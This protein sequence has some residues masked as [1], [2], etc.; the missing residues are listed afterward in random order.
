MKAPEG[1][2]GEVM[3][4]NRYLALCGVASR[5]GAMELVF[6]ERVSVNA[7]LAHDPGMEIHC[8]EDRVTLDGEWVRP[9]QHWVVYAF[10]KPRGVV[11]SM[12]DELGR[13]GLRPYLRRIREAVFPVGRLDSNSE[14]ILLLTNHGELGHALLHP[15][16]HVE[17]V[18]QVSVV[19]R[20]HR[21]QLGRMMAGV[22]IGRGEWGAPAMVRV[23]RANR[24]GAVLRMTML[25]GKKREVRRICRAV[26]L[27]VTRLRR[28]SFAGIPLGELAPGAHRDLS[29]SELAALTELTGLEL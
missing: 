28:L 17:K 5:R 3:R 9:P 16:F 21:G 4:L 11:V 7:Q 14:G 19:P 10:H 22:D 13:E 25:E 6:G 23:K 29:R 15:R 8:G 27:K 18:Y 12:S 20:P 26:G 2:R 24:G 1:P